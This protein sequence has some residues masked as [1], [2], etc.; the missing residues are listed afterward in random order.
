MTRQTKSSSRMVL[1]EDIKNTNKTSP[2]RIRQ[3]EEGKKPLLAGG[4]N[5][6]LATS[7]SCSQAL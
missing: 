3:M 6:M 7:L 5:T 4:R 2:T 1:D